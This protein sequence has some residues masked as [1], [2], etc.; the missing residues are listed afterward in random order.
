MVAKVQLQVSRLIKAFLERVLVCG[1]AHFF[2]LLLLPLFLFPSSCLLLLFISE[3]GF[4][5]TH[6]FGMALN[7][8]FP[9]TAQDTACLKYTKAV[10]C[11]GFVKNPKN[12]MDA[13]ETT[14]ATQGPVA[15]TVSANWATYGGGIF[16]D[17]CSNIPGYSCT[18]DH[19]VVAV[20]YT[21]DYWLV[22]NSWGDSWG[23]KG[24]IRLTRKYDN[25]TF[26]DTNPT[27]GDACKPYPAKQY[28]M[29]E[30][31]ILFDTSYPTGVKR[32][33]AEP[34]CKS[35]EFCC[36][37]AKHCLTPTHV[38]CLNNANA[39]SSDQVC[40]P[41]TKVCVDVGPA[42]TSPCADQGSYCCPDAK[43]CLTPVPGI[44]CNG[45]AKNCK[46]G[47]VCCPVTD[48]CVDV[49]AACVPS[50]TRS[51]QDIMLTPPRK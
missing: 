10:T 18:L 48:L 35:S 23:E 26:T 45:D 21:K 2:L 19:A 33:S 17:G 49:G 50:S 16:S 25:T 40:C 27:E 43:H 44:F 47:Q 39:C 11:E 28:P 29:G 3:L 42:C 31:G 36:P 8:D 15:I 34:V 5:Y 13:L 41:L 9:Y 4:N 51:F 37:D 38:S 22:R 1:I 32:A 12:S 20:G 6:N 30:S 14:L 24:Y 7:K 46:S